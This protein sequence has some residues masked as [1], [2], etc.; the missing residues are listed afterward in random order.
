MCVCDIYGLLHWAALEMRA[1]LEFKQKCALS[2]GYECRERWDTHLLVHQIRRYLV[3]D[4]D[5]VFRVR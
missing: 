1:G 2:L 5:Q 4:P 3:S